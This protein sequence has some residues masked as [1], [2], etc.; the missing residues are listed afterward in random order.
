MTGTHSQVKITVKDA[1]VESLEMVYKMNG[2]IVRIFSFVS[3]RDVF[4]H[5]VSIPARSLIHGLSKIRS[6]LKRVYQPSENL[7]SSSFS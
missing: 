6:K 3:F 7:N 1:S 2:F 4:L 5:F